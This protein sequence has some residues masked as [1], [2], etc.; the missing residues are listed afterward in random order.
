MR[1]VEEERNR[2]LSV[3]PGGISNGEFGLPP[4]R[5]VVLERGE[6]SRLWDTTGREWLDF[7]L[8]WGSV[9]VGH[10]RPEIVAAVAAQVPRGSNFGVPEPARARGRRGD[11]MRLSG[12]GATALLRVGHRGHDVLRAP[13]ARLDRTRAHRQVRR[14]LPRG[15]RNGGHE[16]LSARQPALSLPGADERGHPRGGAPGASRALQRFRRAPP[17]ARPA[18]RRSRR[19]HHGA[20]AALHYAPSRLP[21]SG[22]GGVHR[23]RRAPHL[24]RSGH[25][26][27]SRL[28]GRSGVLRRGAGPGGLRQG[29]RRRLIRSEPSAAVRI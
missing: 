10:A 17:P 22:A 7:S 5:L 27:P 19:G 21:R 29:S 25:R 26:V 11:P 16:P 2:A 1:E 3:F 28:R 12:G 13:G 24:R 6:G 4:D 23:E 20:P 18:R 15:E 9:L 8:G 14:R